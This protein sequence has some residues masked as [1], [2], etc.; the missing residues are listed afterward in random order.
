[1]PLIA[2]IMLAAASVGSQLGATATRYVDADRIRVLFGITV[3][4]GSV[5]IALK[6]VSESG[7]NLEYLN[8]LAAVILLG[9]SGIMAMVI[10]GLLL[11][12]KLGSSSLKGD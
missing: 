12:A 9:V 4:S 11:R 7:T 5:A 8:V 10:G 3:L 1:D 6:Q 2:I